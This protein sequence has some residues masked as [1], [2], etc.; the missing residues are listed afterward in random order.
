MNSTTDLEGNVSWQKIVSVYA[1]PDLRK[2]IWQIV[3]TLIPFFG[4]FYL[5]MRSVEISLWL[6]LPLTILTAGFLIRSFI[7]FH[8]CGHGSFFKS[9]RA[10]DWTGV[11]TGL[12][13]FTPYYRWK[14]EHAIH[15]AT[16]GDL[17]RRRHPGQGARRDARR[18][19]RAPRDDRRRRV[20]AR[21]RARGRPPLARRARAPA[22]RA[23]S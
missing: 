16:S 1:K 21:R 3:N 18:G 2:S 9:Q 22:R 14:H 7:I 4:L 6:T 8:D 10:N 11:I 13:A 20:R 5:S 17:D 15:H 12:L 19:P 23:R